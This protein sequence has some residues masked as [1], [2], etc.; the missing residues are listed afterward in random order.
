M[1]LRISL[2]SFLLIGIIAYLVYGKMSDASRKRTPETSATFLSL[3][4]RVFLLPYSLTPDIPPI[5]NPSPPFGD[6]SKTDP[7][8][9]IHERISKMIK[10]VR[11]FLQ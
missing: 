11:I 8:N 3:F 9:T 5:P 7:I 2:I 6:M 4:S 1:Y 10:R